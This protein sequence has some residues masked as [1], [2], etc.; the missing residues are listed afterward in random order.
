MLDKV[1][2]V[3]NLAVEEKSAWSTVSGGLVKGLEQCLLGDA[4]EQSSPQH[5][6]LVSQTNDHN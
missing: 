4:L 3:C 5:V 6:E 1:K 2:Q